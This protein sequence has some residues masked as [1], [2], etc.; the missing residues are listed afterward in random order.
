MKQQKE[1]SFCF[2]A[3]QKTLKNTVALP[4]SSTRLVTQHSLSTGVAKA[5]LTG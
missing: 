1:L 3:A 2:K 5:Y 4:K